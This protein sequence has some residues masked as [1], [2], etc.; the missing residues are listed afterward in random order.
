MS[1][2]FVFRNSRQASFMP[3]GMPGRQYGERR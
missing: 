2:I 1:A 3:V